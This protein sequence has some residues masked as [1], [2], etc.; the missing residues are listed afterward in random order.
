MAFSSM[1]LLISPLL[2]TLILIG[3]VALLLDDLHLVTVY[4]LVTTSSLSL[5]KVKVSYPAPTSKPNK[6]CCQFRCWDMLDSQPPP[7]ASLTPYQGNDRLLWQCLCNLHVIHNPVQHQRTKH[8]EIDIHFVCDQVATGAIQVLHVPS[9]SQYA[10][11]FT[12]G[13][14][15]TL[16]NGFRSSLNVHQPPIQIVGDVS[17]L[18]YLCI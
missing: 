2:L 4:F 7:R 17:I 1:S 6:R 12:K 16:F 10:Y 18:L 8:T 9:A 15:F 11:I 13:L 3:V 5:R 14:S